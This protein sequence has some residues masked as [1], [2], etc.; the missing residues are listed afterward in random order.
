MN[1]TQKRPVAVCFKDQEKDMI[2]LLT[3]TGGIFKAYEVPFWLAGEGL[4]MSEAAKQ[5]DERA[6]KEEELTSPQQP[7]GLPAGMGLPSNLF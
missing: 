2:D 3:K 4:L 5:F 7:P 6:K 1:K